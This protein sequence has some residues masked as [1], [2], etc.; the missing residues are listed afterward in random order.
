MRVDSTSFVGGRGAVPIRF[1]VTQPARVVT[2]AIG[3][4]GGSYVID[5]SAWN[6]QVNLSWPARVAN[7]DPVPAG[8]FTVVVEARPGQKTS[9]PSQQI[10]GG[11]GNVDNPPSLTSLPGSQNL[12]QTSG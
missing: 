2:R 7:G 10:R 3:T 4:A 6:G 8:V 9:A 5:S 1:T 12:P 11:P